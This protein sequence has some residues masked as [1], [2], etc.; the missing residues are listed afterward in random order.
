MQLLKERG[1]RYRHMK[2]FQR[3]LRTEHFKP[4]R[5]AN[6]LYTGQKPRLLYCGRVSK[7]KNLAFMVQSYRQLL[8]KH[9]DACLTIV[10]D[11]PYLQELKADCRDLPNVDFLGRVDYQQLPKIYNSH[12]LFLFPSITDT[13]GMAVLEAQ[14]CGLPAL[15]SDVGG[16]K[17]IVAN[18]QTGHV[19]PVSYPADWAKVLDCMLRDLKEGGEAYALMSKTARSR[20]E[21]NYSWDRILHNM[22]KADAI[23]TPRRHSVRQRSPFNRFLKLA[24]S[25]MVG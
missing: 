15:V 19:L 13:F 7:D 4:E 14:A 10:G 11:G 24:S 3:G 22:V 5:S 20:V 8:T 21:N 18:G 1:Y 16:P 17:E 12:D 9:A 2:R 23:D 25:M 6:H